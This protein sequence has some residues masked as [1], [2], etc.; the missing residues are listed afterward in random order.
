[1]QR[2]RQLGEGKMGCIFGLAILV[3]A[4]FV[5]LK[6]IPKRVAVASLQ[7]FIEETAQRASLL[8]DQPNYP[9]PAQLTD[10]FY[11]KAKEEDLPV[12]KE[13]IKVNMSN[14][15]V[16]VEIKYVVDI[17]LAVTKYQWHVEHKVERMTF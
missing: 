13:D 17:D 4:A 1:M 8:S 15:R 12:H 6:V 10:K 11:Q 5:A 14:G 9:I 7:D 3:I 2:M 16:F